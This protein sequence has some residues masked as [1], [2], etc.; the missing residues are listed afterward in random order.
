[1]EETNGLY[2]AITDNRLP[3]PPEPAGPNASARVRTPTFS[4]TRSPS[5]A[6][7]GRTSQAQ[8]YPLVE[9]SRE[10]EAMLEAYGSVSTTGYLLALEGEAGIGKTRLAAALVDYAR[11]NGST[12]LTARCYEGES[13]LAYGPLVA[14]LRGALDRPSRWRA[15]VR[16]PDFLKVLAR[17]WPPHW[18]TG[19][20]CS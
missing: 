1:M 4:P 5:L 10:W 7:V 6:A 20:C 16:R 13:G 3:E 2:E 12:A 9:R 11:N 14:C 15:P 19:A 18:E 17:C 8:A